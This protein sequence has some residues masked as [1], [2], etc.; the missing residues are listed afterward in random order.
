MVNSSQ[1]S[2]EINAY[3]LNSRVRNDLI[4]LMPEK[5]QTVLEIG[6]GIG[7]TGKAI[8]QQKGSQI[9]GIDLSLEAIEIARQQ[10][11]YEKLIVC[12]LDEIVIPPE[13]QNIC[14]DC[15]LY[16]D[17]LEHLKNPWDVIQQHLSLLKPNGV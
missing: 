7:R 5:P 6:C 16:P 10:D 14:F 1:T 12:D 3:F 4:E 2:T 9:I 8:I 15:I 11:C 13:I 17:V